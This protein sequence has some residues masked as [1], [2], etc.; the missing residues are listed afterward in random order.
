MFIGEGVWSDFLGKDLGGEENFR[1]LRMI[2]VFQ[3]KARF[4]TNLCEED[5][6][7]LRQS[8]GLL[9]DE[10]VCLLVDDSLFGNRAK[11]E[12]K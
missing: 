6:L 2:R 5:L 3:Q 4:C 12:T 10:V 1:R 8:A 9:E 11:I 7:R